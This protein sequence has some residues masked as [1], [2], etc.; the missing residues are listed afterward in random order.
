[1]AVITIS[2]NETLKEYISQRGTTAG[3]YVRMLILQDMINP[4]T[5]EKKKEL[6]MASMYLG[7]NGLEKT[8]ELFPKLFENI[9]PSTVV[10]SSS[11]TIEPQV[12]A[13]PPSPVVKPKGKKVRP[14]IPSIQ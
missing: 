3:V 10:E 12:V 6:E 14:V 5:E 13:E 2:L 8:K 4:M 11:V 1:M 7:K 9:E